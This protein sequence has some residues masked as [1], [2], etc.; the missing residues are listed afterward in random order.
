MA[1]NWK[2]ILGANIVNA[3]AAMEQA[4]KDQDR[5]YAE[6]EAE[7]MQK[8]L[9]YNRFMHQFGVGGGAQSSLSI[10]PNGQIQVSQKISTTALGTALGGGGTTYTFA[11][12]G[13]ELAPPP[14]NRN[15][16]EK[17]KTTEPRM[18][19]RRMPDSICMMTGW[20]AW[21]TVSV[22]GEWRLKAL[23]QET[24]WEPKKKMEAIC[25]A[26]GVSLADPAGLLWR[27][28]PAPF[29]SCLC[30]FWAF[31]NVEMLPEAL[32]GQN[33]EHGATVIGSI[34]M[35]GHVIETD[36]GFRAENAYPKELW[37]LKDGM[38]DLGWIYGVPIR[39]LTAENAK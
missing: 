28:H 30:G 2:G 20:R 24:I 33:H 16:I 23:G 36:I 9:G 26:D 39:T 37:L 29:Q 6:V 3:N 10:D 19:T 8:Q 5:L 13:G 7:Q 4:K 35:W 15:A 17:F 12:L 25:K 31:K 34:H 27:D 1:V 14:V 38:E 22:N 18:V 32:L 11:M 21:R